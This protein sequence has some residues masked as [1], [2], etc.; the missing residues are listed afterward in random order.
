MARDLFYDKEH[1]REMMYYRDGS[2]RRGPRGRYTMDYETEYRN[3]P[4]WD[5]H[6]LLKHIA[7][8]KDDEGEDIFVYSIVDKSDYSYYK[9]IPQADAAKDWYHRLPSGLFE[10]VADNWFELLGAEEDLKQH[11]I[12]II[13]R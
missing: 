6:V 2:P 10:E 4:F 8:D 9:R 3:P 13:Q 12:T 1:L 7:D 11:N 5:T